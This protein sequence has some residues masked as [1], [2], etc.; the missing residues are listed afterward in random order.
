MNDIKNRHVLG[1]PIAHVHVIEF[2][3]RGLPHCHMLIILR[4]EDKLRDSNDIDKIISAEIP[5]QNEDPEL[6]EIV[7]LCMIHGPCGLLNPKSVCMEN[8]TCKKK[9]PKEFRE[10]TNENVNGYPAYRRRNNDIWSL[11][12]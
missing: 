11:C 5:D 3:K 12:C 9:F 2:Q 7:K 8:G 6:Y 1:V 10:Q 4:D